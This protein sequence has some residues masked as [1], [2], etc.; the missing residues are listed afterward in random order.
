MVY[1]LI[2]IGVRYLFMGVFNALYNKYKDK[3]KEW[4]NHHHHHVICHICLTAEADIF[5]PMAVAESDCYQC[6][7]R[8][9]L[10]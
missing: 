3:Y 2:N 9:Q 7:Y 1:I 10:P 6:R 4:C 8:F 5:Q